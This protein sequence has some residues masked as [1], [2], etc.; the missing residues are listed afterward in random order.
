MLACDVGF[1][2]KKELEEANE[3]CVFRG[4]RARRALQGEE[5]SGDVFGDGRRVVEEKRI[6]ELW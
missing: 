3:V 5:W 4:G 6:V 2:N 1:L